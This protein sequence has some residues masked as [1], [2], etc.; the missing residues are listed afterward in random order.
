MTDWIEWHKKYEAPESS[1]ARRLSVVRRRIGEA[2]DQLP[3]GNI[4]V[5]SMCAGDGRDLLGVLAHHPRA[6]DVTGR[7]VEWNSQLVDRARAAAPSTIEVLCGDAGISDSYDGAVPVDLLLCC[8]VLGNI[9]EEDIHKTIN[10][11]SMLCSPQAIVIWTRGSSEPDIRNELRQ[12]VHEAGFEELSFDGMEDS[13]GVGVAKRSGETKPYERGVRFFSF[14]P[15]K[16]GCQN[17]G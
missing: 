14:V 16:R 17:D 1:L 4:R 3:P 12:W 6:G 9:T 10:S 15:E 7:L 5:I 13:Y 2:L 11:W 8:G